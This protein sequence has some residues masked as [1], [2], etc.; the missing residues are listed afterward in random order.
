MSSRHPCLEPYGTRASDGALAGLATSTMARYWTE[1]DAFDSSQ[2]MGKE[3]GTGGGGGGGG[4]GTM[5]GPLMDSPAERPA[6][7]ATAP[8]AE[9]AEDGG[10]V[11]KSEGGFDEGSV[12]AGYHTSACAFR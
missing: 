3:A 7:G 9:V 2:P 4:A 8:R 10:F 12:T 1:G 11:V 6:A 5:T